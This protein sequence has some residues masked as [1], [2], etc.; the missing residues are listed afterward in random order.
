[1]NDSRMDRNRSRPGVRIGGITG[2]LLALLGIFEVTF[3]VLSLVAALLGGIARDADYSSRASTG[4]KVTMLEPEHPAPQ[5]Q[6]PVDEIQASRPRGVTI[7]TLLLCFL[8]LIEIV[9][10]ALALVTS[11]LGSFVFPLRSAAVGAALGVYFL[12][13]GLM[14]LF[15][16]W[17]LYRLQRWAF[18]A[19]VFISA[20]SLLSSILAVTEPAPTVW[21]FLADLLIPGVILV[22]LVA[23]SNV[24]NAFRS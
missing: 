23:D 19:T 24:R 1:M 15:L 10:G 13:V 18:W 7:I 3:D 6:A 22:Y 11:L 21:A 17:G 12:L 16:A 14:K 2:M 5:P 20:V 8:G 4:T 9:F